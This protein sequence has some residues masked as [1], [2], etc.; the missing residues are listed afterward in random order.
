M[1]TILIFKMKHSMRLDIHMYVCIY[2]LN[3]LGIGIFFFGTQ[4][5]FL[6]D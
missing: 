6:E 3:I 4:K 1:V 5:V 2:V